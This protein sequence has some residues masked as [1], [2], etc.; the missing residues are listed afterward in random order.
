[1]FRTQFCMNGYRVLK[2]WKY[3]Y[4]DNMVNL[5]R[6]L[7]NKYKLNDTYWIIIKEAVQSLEDLIGMLTHFN[8]YII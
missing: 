7:N 3:I 6:I 2:I 4:N 1:M 8:L 5:F